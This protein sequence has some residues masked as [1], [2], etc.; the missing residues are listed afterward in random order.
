LLL[1]TP[2]RYVALGFV[3]QK[4]LAQKA[5]DEEK[6][7]DKGKARSE[8]KMSNLG[9]TARDPVSSLLDQMR[10]QQPNIL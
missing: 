1:V 3:E 4:S 5:A 8:R 10:C 7:K 2:Q 6:P 9:T